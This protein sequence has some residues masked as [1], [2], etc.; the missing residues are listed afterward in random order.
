MYNEVYA[1][2]VEAGVAVKLN[3]P[4]W[5]D[6]E[7]NETTKENAFGQKATHQLIHPDYV[8]FVDE[9]GCNTSQ[10][11]DGS[12]GGEKKIVGRGTAARI[13]AATNVNHFTVL[14]FTA[15]TGEPVM[16]GVI[17]QGETVRADVITGIDSFAEK[18]GC[19]EDPDF[20][21][22]NTG[23]GKLFPMGPTCCFKGVEVPC[24]VACS[25][26]G[27]ITSEILMQ[28]LKK[29]DELDLFPRDE[30]GLKPFLLLDG[31]GSRLELPF[32]EYVNNPSNPW[33]VCIG[34]P[35][36][37]SYWQV[38]DSSE[39]NG[40]YKIAMTKSKQELVLKKQ[41]MCWANARVETYE[42][43]VVLNAAWDKSFSRVSYNKEAIAARGWGPLTQNLLDNSEIL[44]TATDEDLLLQHQQDTATR[45]DPPSLASTLNFSNGL[46]NTLI[47]D[48]LQNIDREAV[49][50]QI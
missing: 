5:V 2:M 12:R 37:T 35:Y 44:A 49:R 46:S 30:C 13:S 14:G 48:I 25:T 10:E 23:K 9:V 21:R 43:M 17:I 18:I 34:V 20:V 50:D 11:G 4:I 42:I 19:D 15:A 41:R 47:V 8:I 38:G 28:F 36:G 40:S 16:C 33:V 26:N 1:G 45:N 3:E 31:H 7:G 29:M 32:L 6:K 39:Q 24:M 27:S 22:L